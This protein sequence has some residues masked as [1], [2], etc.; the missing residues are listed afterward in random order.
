MVKRAKKDTKKD[1]VK[2]VENLLSYGLIAKENSGVIDRYNRGLDYWRG[3]HPIRMKKY[4]RVFNK[5]AEIVETRI[6]QRIY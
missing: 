3:D 6:A 1:E 4:G 5:F 2:I